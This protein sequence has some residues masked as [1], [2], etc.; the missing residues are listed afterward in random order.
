MILVLK[1]KRKKK[2]PNKKYNLKY[3]NEH[4]SSALI[5]A[6]AAEEKKGES[7]LLLDVSKLTI[8]TDYFLMIT[9]KSSPQIQAIAKYLEEKLC[10]LNCKLISKE[11]YIQSNWLVL[12][13]GNI[14]VHI[15][16]EEERNYYKLERFWSN[17]TLIDKKLWKKAS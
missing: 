6:S 4:L 10:K 16:N 17:A 1:A 15:M 14:V 8:I 11:G 7:I 12:D 2:E 9:A 5:A 13:F 3:K